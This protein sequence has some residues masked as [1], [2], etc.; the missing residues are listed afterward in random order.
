[1]IRAE[2]DY[3]LRDLFESIARASR[4][5]DREHSVMKQ[6]I[7]QIDAIDS[8]LRDQIAFDFEELVMKFETLFEN[9]ECQR[10][11]DSALIRRLIFVSNSFSFE[12]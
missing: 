10:H 4:E 1:M 2:K 8:H 3:V 6:I 7:R 5:D 9:S 11:A 12:I